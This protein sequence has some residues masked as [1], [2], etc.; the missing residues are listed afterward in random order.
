MCGKFSKV[1]LKNHPN[2]DLF[3]LILLS[4]LDLFQPL[5]LF[6]GWFLLRKAVAH[7]D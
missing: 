5:F 1:M 3:G 4:F 2:S 6:Q 7:G